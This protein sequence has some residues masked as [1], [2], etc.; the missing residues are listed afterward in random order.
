MRFKIITFLF[1]VLISRHDFALA[2]QKP[3]KKDSTQI[4]SDIESFSKRG[5]FT[6]FMYSLIFK[7]VVS[8]STQKKGKKKVYKKLIQ[9]PYGA[10]EGKIIRNINIETLDPFGYSIGDTI[11][12]EPNFLSKAGNELHVKSQRITIRN[13][14]LIH[15][16][17][18]FD[19]LLVKESERLVR[20]QRYIRDVSF[21]VKAAA[22]GSD[23]VDV[24]IRE[25]D[26]WDR[27]IG[28]VSIESLGI[29]PCKITL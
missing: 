23:S 3:V 25:L 29:I 20:S 22:K 21:F 16:N 4:Y 9:K 14:L 17:Q 15:Q 2:Q 8:T 6:K 28:M 7:P 1:L 24:F 26:I 27:I 19:S 5:K 13:L 18:V 12:R 10:F 11:F